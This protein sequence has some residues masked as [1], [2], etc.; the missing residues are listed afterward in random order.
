MIRWLHTISHVDS[1]AIWLLI[2]FSN[3]KC[4]QLR[5]SSSGC[6]FTFDCVLFMHS[7]IEKGFRRKL[8]LKHMTDSGQIEPNGMKLVGKHPTRTNL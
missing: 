8:H 7:L 1:L 2:P 6:C 5:C 4:I 3:T